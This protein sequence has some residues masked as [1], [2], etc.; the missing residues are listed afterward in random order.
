MRGYTSAVNDE[1]TPEDEAWIMF[2]IEAGRAKM[3]EV[4]A[5]IMT[6]DA[7]GELR[8]AALERFRDA[9]GTDH[10]R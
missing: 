9:V 3:R 2:W 6:S 7:P 8:Q 4:E 10:L 5:A 1:F